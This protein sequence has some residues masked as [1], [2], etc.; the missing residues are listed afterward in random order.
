MDLRNKRIAILGATSHIA[1]GLALNFLKDGSG[2]VFLFSRVPGKVSRFLKEYAPEK[3]WHNDGFKEFRNG[4][5]DVVINCVGLGAPSRISREGANIFSLTEKFDDLVLRYLKLHPRAVY[6]NFSSGAVHTIT[7]GVLK[8]EHF[9][10]IAKLYQEAKHRVLTEFNIVDIRVFSYFSRFIDLDSGYFLT[11]LIKCI[12]RGSVFVTTPCDF[13]RDFLSSEDLYR[14]VRLVIR[15]R[16]FNDVVEAYSSKTVS[17]FEL[18]DY[19]SRKHSLR[20][21]VKQGVRLNCPTGRKDKYFSTS[22]KAKVLLGYK[23]KFSSLQTVMKE[24]G[25]LLDG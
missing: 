16:P 3:G 23:P 4:K 10:G 21:K 24:A 15:A 8:P 1:K 9:Y 17:K 6:I 11:E 20:Y 7:P 18:L 14:L 22:N 2:E 19:F 25:Y 5:Y 13:T 12:K